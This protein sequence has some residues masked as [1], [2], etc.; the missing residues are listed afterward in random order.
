M[1]IFVSAFICM[2]NSQSTVEWKLYSSLTLGRLTKGTGCFCQGSKAGGC[3]LVTAQCAT[4]A[5]GLSGTEGNIPLDFAGR[6]CVQPWE[7]PVVALWCLFYGGR[8]VPLS[9]AVP[10]D[11]SCWHKPLLCVFKVKGE[12]PNQIPFRVS[13]N[14]LVLLVC[15]VQ[16]GLCEWFPEQHWMC[17]NC[18]RTIC[19]SVTAFQKVAPLDQCKWVFLLK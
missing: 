6:S 4:W 9:G 2:H 13:P 14:F 12:K 1:C 15:P 10:S 5:L 7:R 3:P 8:D 11:I 16:T 18:I 17:R 19:I